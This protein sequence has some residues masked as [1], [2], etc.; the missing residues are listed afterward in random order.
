MLYV[1]RILNAELE[2]SRRSFTGNNGGNIMPSR[3]TFVGM[4]MAVGGLPIVRPLVA[5]AAERGMA[6]QKNAPGI[7]DSEIKI[8]QTM[9]YSGPVSAY[10]AIG[11]AQLAYFR[12]INDQGGINGRKINLI[13]LDDGYSPP[14]T[15]EQIRRLVEQD[16]VAFIFQS[17]GDVTN[18]AVQRYLNERHVPQLFLA[19]GSSIWDDPQHFPWSMGWQ[20]SYRTAAHIDAK[21]ILE[22]K[23]DAKIAVLVQDSLGGRD[24]LNGVK[25][26]LAA[27]RS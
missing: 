9:P 6:E 20:P 5:G 23:P 16:Q 7:T 24:Y 4:A 25:E 10:G 21:Y 18:A 3:R 13:S 26:A 2:K 15:V 14:K 11:R 1:T 19:D 12:M 22:N 17:L 27:C 8:G